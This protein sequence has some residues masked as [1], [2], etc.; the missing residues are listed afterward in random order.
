MFAGVFLVLFS[1][2]AADVT[3]DSA[4]ERQPARDASGTSI[5]Q[6]NNTIV[7]GI[8]SKDETEYPLAEKKNEAVDSYNT[9]T[10]EEIEGSNVKLAKDGKAKEGEERVPMP[11]DE[12]SELQGVGSHDQ[13]EKSSTAADASSNGGSK[14]EES[15]YGTSGKS[16]STKTITED[17]YRLSRTNGLTAITSK[18]ASDETRADETRNRTVEVQVSNDSLA[19]EPGKVA[20]SLEAGKG[21]KE[22]RVREEASSDSGTFNP[23]SESAPQKIRLVI[24]STDFSIFFKCVVRVIF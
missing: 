1:A 23:G 5:F 12:N 9:T 13:V 2:V 19:Q 16:S 20:K 21:L 17:S 6:K 7:N 3:E 4:S 22:E 11:I 8:P 10:I 24:T 18:P 15:I 14:L